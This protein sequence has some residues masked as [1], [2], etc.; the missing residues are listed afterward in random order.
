MKFKGFAVKLAI[1]GVI[2]AA[3]VVCLIMFYSDIIGIFFY[4]I[5][6]L[7]PFI[8]AFI[9]SLAADPLA[10]K[11]HSRFKL[12]RGLTAILVIILIVGIIGGALAGVIWKLISE[13]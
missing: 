3:L 11:L 10:E 1:A 4:I 13:L 5:R 7:A 8:I 6:L 12:P 2:I 9:L